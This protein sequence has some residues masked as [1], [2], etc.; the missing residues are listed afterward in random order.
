MN[1]SDYLYKIAISLVP[2][3]G[4][5]SAKKL[6]AY[7]GS[8]ESIFAERK[9]LLTKI[10]GIGTKLAGEILNA[11]EALLRAEE[12]INFATKFNI[13]ILY[14]L[15][16][17]YPEKLKNCEDAPLILYSKGNVDYNK[18]KM[19]SV[20]GTRRNTSYGKDICNR[21]ISELAETHPDLIIVSGL[22]SGI[23]V[24]AHKAALNNQLKTIAVMAHGLDRIYPAAHRQIAKDIVNNGSL[25][26]EYMSNTNPDTGNFVMRNRIVAGLS[27]ATLVIESG[28]KG[29]A[30]ITANIAISYN[31]DVLAV[32]GRSSDTYSKGCNWLIKTNR[33]ALIEEAADIEYA[34]GWQSKNSVQK[35]KTTPQLFVELTEQEQKILDIIE[36]EKE[37]NID[38]LHYKS[39][40]PMPLLS[41]ILLNLEFNGLVK[42]LPG[43]IYSP[44]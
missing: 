15:N 13:E 41:G 9:S 12:E 27:D 22:A 18:Q 10:P 44:Y 5:V 25:A 2:G 30:L 23:D 4:P 35:Q 36:T 40:M 19:L 39:N 14:Y 24:I 11:K 28:I 37:A 32:A 6:I 3:I 1:N 42:S 20:V 29:G 43:K 17:N 34:L 33:A 26:T 21:L 7:C 31:R 8:V 38:V 16:D